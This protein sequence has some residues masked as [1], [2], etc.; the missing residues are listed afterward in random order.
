[1]GRVAQFLAVYLVLAASAWAQGNPVRIPYDDGAA[2]AEGGNI[3]AKFCSACHGG[4]R[5]GEPDWRRRNDHGYLPAPPHDASGHTW[6]HPDGKL[7]RIVKLG[8][9]A[10]AGADYKS[11]MNGFGHL[12]TDEEILQV[13]AFIK[14]SW[15][16]RLIDYQN[17]VSEGALS[18]HGY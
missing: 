11:R 1:M 4:N 8:V 3:Y 6:Q 17:R 18:D 7:F 5:T 14:S 10:V 15:P 13:L 12:L 9:E 2:V 16:D